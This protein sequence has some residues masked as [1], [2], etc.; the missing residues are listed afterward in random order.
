M[1]NAGDLSEGGKLSNRSPLEDLEQSMSQMTHENE[2]LRA[3]LVKTKSKF[4]EFECKQHEHLRKKHKEMHSI[5]KEL[6]D[7]LVAQS[8]TQALLLDAVEE[9]RKIV[10][11]SD[12]LKVIATAPY[13]C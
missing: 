3:E 11:A 4:R 10:Q 6:R 13:M 8:D 2:L 7:A 9:K 5:K 1:S 12:A